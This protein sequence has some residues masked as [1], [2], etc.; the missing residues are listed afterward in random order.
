MG[1]LKVGTDL[2]CA[3]AKDVRLLVIGMSVYGVVL[4]QSRGGLSFY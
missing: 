1:V 3:R 2:L 4:A